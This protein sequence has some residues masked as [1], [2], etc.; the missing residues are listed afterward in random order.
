MSKNIKFD[1]DAA[2]VQKEFENSFKK[3]RM[4]VKNEIN[5]DSAPFM[6]KTYGYL[7]KSANDSVRKDDGFLVWN[8]VKAKFLYYG[9]VMVGKF[10]R[11]AWA[12]KNEEKEVINKKLKYSKVVNPK[13]GA[14]WFEN[15]KKINKKRWVD[16]MKRIGGGRQ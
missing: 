3:G 2:K 15:A 1:F 8:S 13:A 14:F 10:S 16:I 9:K 7:E 4:Q 12:K 11:S 5:R 6:P